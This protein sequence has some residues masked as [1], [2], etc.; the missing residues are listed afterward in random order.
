MRRA[1]ILLAAVVVMAGAWAAA[2]PSDRSSRSASTPRASGGSG[3]SKQAALEAKLE[4]ILANQRAILEKS[5]KV[6]EEIRIIQ[7]RASSRASPQ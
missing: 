7:V 5:G 2:E 6:M 1:L 3:K 4:Q